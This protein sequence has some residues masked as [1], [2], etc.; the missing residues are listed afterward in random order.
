MWASVWARQDSNPHALRHRNDTPA[1]LPISPLA[2]LMKLNDA[3]REEVKLV[4]SA[5][6]NVYI[7]NESPVRVEANQPVTLSWAGGTALE[8]VIESTLY[9]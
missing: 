5:P 6:K 4:F 7:N 8:L 9:T 3:L 1:C 2:T